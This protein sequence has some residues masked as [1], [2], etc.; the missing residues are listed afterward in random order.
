MPGGKSTVVHA[1]TAAGLF[2]VS[3]PDGGVAVAAPAAALGRLAPSGVFAR[4]PSELLLA[5]SSHL[6][7]KGSGGGGGPPAEPAG[8][9]LHLT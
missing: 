7:H 1:G 8:A 2:S 9:L 3:L 5:L 4:E 6:G